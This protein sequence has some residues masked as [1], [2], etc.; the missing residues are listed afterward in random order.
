MKQRDLLSR[1]ERSAHMAR[2]R[3]TGNRSTEG[4]VEEV[5][6]EREIAGWTKHSR[7]V[8]GTPDFYF[9]GYRLALFVHGCFWH[10]CPRCNRRVPGTRRTFWAKKLDD[11][12]RRDQR[13]RRELWKKG[14]HVVRIWEHQ[15]RG[16]AWVR[17]LES[18]M[19]QLRDRLERES[20]TR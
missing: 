1:E 18:K 19:R 15:L 20:E 11:N 4:R 9:P 6:K 17:R 8:P 16:D 13:V 7:D 12:R 3:S 14:Y 2:V 10:V 5:L